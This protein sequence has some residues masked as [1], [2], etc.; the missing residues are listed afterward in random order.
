MHICVKEED[1]IPIP[2]FA[3]NPSKV[4]Q[5]LN[6]ISITDLFDQDELMN[7]GQDLVTLCQ[8]FG[9]VEALEIP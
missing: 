8:T 9:D 4:V 2:L 6:M 1:K 3:L 5:F 7:V